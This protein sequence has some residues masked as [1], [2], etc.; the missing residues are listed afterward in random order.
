[1]HNAINL[2]DDT[3]ERSVINAIIA[4]SIVAALGEGSIYAFEQ[5]YLGK[6][7]V[8]DIDWVKKIIESK[9]SSQF[10]E[11]VTDALKTISD[12]TDTKAITQT[13]LEL[14]TSK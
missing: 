4:G 13:I 6:K 2:Y 8:E 11:K 12:K 7:T 10:I 1:M 14:F 3:K 5:V 9:L